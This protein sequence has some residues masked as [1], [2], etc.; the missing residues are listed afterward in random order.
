[1]AAPVHLVVEKGH[2][3]GRKISVPP[4]G[5]RLGRSSRNDIVLVD[6]LLSRYHCRLFFKPGEGLCVADLGSANQTLVNGKPVQ[7]RRL[8][9]GDILTVGETACR[10]LQD[11][12]GPAA[13]D[14]APAVDLGLESQAAPPRRLLTPRV[15]SLA[16][17][18]CAVAA[19]AAAALWMVLPRSE[20]APA[21]PPPV[22]AR[23]KPGVELSYEKIEADASNIFRY[24]L[25]IAGENTVSVTIDD[26][27]ND[28]HVRKEERAAPEVVRRLA[29]AVADAGFFA[30]EEAYEGIQPGNVYEVHDL[31]VTI[32]RRTHR[33]RVVNRVEPEVFQH[34]REMVEEF[35]KNE[36]GLLA[37]QF[38]T[39]RLLEMAEEAFLQG[40]KLFDE[41]EIRYG[42]LAAAIKHY[43]EA[44]WYLETVEP[45]PAFYPEI[46]ANITDCKQALSERYD[47]HNFTA[48]RAIRLR[49]WD[50]AARQLRIVTELI[51]DRAD[52]RH[53]SAHKKLLDV[54]RRLETRR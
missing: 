2:D 22:T 39:E 24:A 52:P 36:L 17:T 10:V 9:P 54:E 44:E 18:A 16:L 32:G 40:K 3:T 31:S 35:G 42:N 47:E 12:P 51:P 21:R 49:D 13:G 6:P 43:E 41:R 33:T 15:L 38:S 14:G 27:A 26:L 50:E 34:I 29:D 11:T 46:L 25:R 53:E 19:A 37:I 48:E 4:R 8:R 5:G 7:E 30:L 23:E 1:L 28:R 45:K 20:P